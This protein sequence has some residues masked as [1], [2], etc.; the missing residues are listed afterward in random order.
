MFVR[1]YLVH[2]VIHWIV[3]MP[4]C[5][6]FIQ[7]LEAGLLQLTNKTNYKNNLKTLLS[8]KKLMLTEIQF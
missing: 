4:E 8:L 2:L 5:P 7:V 6:Y 3:E 1:L